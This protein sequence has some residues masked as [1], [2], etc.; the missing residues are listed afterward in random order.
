MEQEKKRPEQGL[1]KTAFEWMSAAVTALVAVAV[2]FTF[3]FRVVSVSGDSMTNTLQH[4]DKLILTNYSY[5][6]QRGDVVVVRRENEEPLIKRVIGLPGDT[7]EIAE[8]RVI[9]NGVPLK[10]PYVRGGQTPSMGMTGRLT[11]PE[12]YVFVMG[13]NRGGSLDSRQLG[14]FSLR[15][16]MGEAVCRLFPTPSF[17]VMESGVDY[18]GL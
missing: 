7:V 9:L 6:P 5:V 8:G 3:F 2:L 16:I 10:E 15:E 14:A 4:G 1:L 18:G 11:V 17:N 13:D 12:G